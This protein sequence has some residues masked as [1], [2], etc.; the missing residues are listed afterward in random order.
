LYTMMIEPGTREMYDL[1][2][3]EWLF[4]TE[5]RDAPHRNSGK[6]RLFTGRACIRNSLESLFAKEGLR[7]ICSRYGHSMLCLLRRIRTAQGVSLD[8]RLRGN[9]RLGAVQCA[10]GIQPFGNVHAS[11]ATFAPPAPPFGACRGAKPLCVSC[12]SPFAKGGPRGIGP[13]DEVVASL[14]HLGAELHPREWG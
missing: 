1:N 13:R 4:G 5:L 14:A 10:P 6:C 11:R 7:G 8:S 3:F 2:Q 12:L 9:D